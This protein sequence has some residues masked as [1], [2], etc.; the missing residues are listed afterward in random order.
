MNSTTRTFICL[1]TISL[2]VPA[3]HSLKE[4]RKQIKSLK[5]KVRSRFNASVAETAH[6]DVWQRAELSAVMISADQRYLEEQCSLLQNMVLEYREL[7]VADFK[8]EWL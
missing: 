1:I 6:Q 5:E 3:S 2:F 7:E 4:K 8:I